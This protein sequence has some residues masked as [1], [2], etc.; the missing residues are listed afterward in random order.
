MRIGKFSF[1]LINDGSFLRDGGC[2]FG[3]VP[4]VSWEEGIKPDRKNRIRLGVNAFLVRTPDSTILVDTG[5]GFKEA[6]EMKETHGLSAGKLLRRLKDLGVTARDI[7]TVILTHLHFDHCGGSTRQDRTG[8]AVPTFPKATYM[9]QKAAWEE[10]CN[11]NERSKNS[12]HPDDFLPL[13]EKGQLRLLDGDSEIMPGVWTRVTGGHCLGHQVVTINPSGER[14]AFL[15]DLIPTPHHIPLQYISAFDQ[16]PQ[17]TLDG[18][19]RFLEMAE[20][21][22]WLLIFG[23]GTDNTAGYLDRRNGEVK[24]RPVEV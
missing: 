16:S 14:I 6:D 15:G 11:P 23:H 3:Q 5:A 4:K 20:N 24:F 18:K 2:M 8:K 1:H 19:R 13:M 9:V 17:D 22:G 12:F 21:E 7:D 10:A